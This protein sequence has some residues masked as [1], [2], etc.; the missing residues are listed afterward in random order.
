MQ[1]GKDPRAIMRLVSELFAGLLG[2]SLLG[3]FSFLWG[4]GVGVGPC[5]NYK[6]TC[7][8][9]DRYCTNNR[10]FVG[11]VERGFFLGD[12][13]GVGYHAETIR[14]VWAECAARA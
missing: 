6:P 13:R 8:H 2:A 4:G 7:S 12:L 10:L 14:R 3:L 1:V 11:E 9:N 5:P